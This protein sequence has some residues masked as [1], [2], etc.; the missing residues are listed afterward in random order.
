M[1]SNN[2]TLRGVIEIYIDSPYLISC[3][4]LYDLLPLGQ[5]AIAS[6]NNAT[7]GDNGGI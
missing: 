3:C 6:F 1:E 2:A 4:K 7:A 5:G